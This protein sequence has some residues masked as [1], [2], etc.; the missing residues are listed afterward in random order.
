[1]RARALVDSSEIASQRRNPRQVTDLPHVADE[2]RRRDFPRREQ[3]AGAVAFWPASVGVS[4][5]IAT[6]DEGLWPLTGIGHCL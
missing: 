6:V 1:L 4:G 2:S 3:F 5:R